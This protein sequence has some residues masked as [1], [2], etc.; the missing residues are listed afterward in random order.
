MKTIQLTSIHFQAQPKR[1]RS[2]VL[3]AIATL[4]GAAPAVHA[5]T[6]P[7]GGRFV[8]GGGTIVSNGNAMTINQNGPRGVLDWDSFSIGHG[9]SVAFN[10]GTGA[11]LNRVTGG[12]LSMIFGTLSATGSVY[13]V[14]PQGIVVGRSGTIATGGRFVAST[15]DANDS[16]FMKGGPLTLA[17]R[18]HAVVVNLG[19]IG[20]SGGDV[21]LIAHDQVLNLG[22]ISAPNGSAELAAGQTVLLQD[23]S[24]SRQVFVKAGSHGNV[25]N[26]GALDAAQI[27]L[28]AADG[29]VF[30][31]SGNHAAIRATGTAKRD[32]HVWLVADTGTVDMEATVSASN[33]NGTGGTVDTSAA[34]FAQD[35]LGATVRAAKWNLTTPR[36]TVTRS[37]GNTLTNS[38]NAG[39]SI[40]VATTQ[41]NIDVGTNL[42]WKGNASLTFDAYGS[43]A[44]DKGV[45][46]RNQGGGDLV[47]RADVTGIDNR[48]SIANNGTLD[49]SASTGIVTALYDMNGRYT[50]GTL[51][52][53]K[54]W[55]PAAGSGLVTQITGYRLVNSF[56]DLQNVSHD[57]AGNYALG[58]NL[59]GGSITPIGDPANAFSGQ[60]DGMGHSIA[61]LSFNAVYSP[62]DGSPLPSGLFGVI[63]TTGVVRNLSVSGSSESIVNPAY[64]M[65]PAG[66][67]AGLNQGH[68]ANVFASGSIFSFDEM[69]LGGLAG[70]NTGLIE[71]SAAS[72]N[73]TGR[74]SYMGG[75]VGQNDGTIAQSYSTGAVQGMQHP[76]VPAGLVGVNTGTIEQSFATGQ[77]TGDWQ[78]SPY[79][80]A[81]TSGNSGTVTADNYWNVE[82]T[83]VTNGGGAPS[84]HGLTTAQMGRASSF[85]GWDFGA[86]GAWLMPAGA[87][88]P[89]LRWQAASA[90]PPQ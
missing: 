48:G 82:T 90:L 3:A 45:A 56:G 74:Q 25:T 41:G 61:N 73:V 37:I 46:I 69:T 77:V 28:Q 67:V 63:G 53:N 79:I 80:G 27:S 36:F 1:F 62:V 10:N 40:D 29:N 50:P 38:L 14:N 32:G 21:V 2:L 66:L 85:A 6:L 89:V 19:Q 12:N 58:K 15:L 65:A 76:S 83:G 17:G 59:Q 20:S 78:V 8:A 57:L 87:T 49:W 72:V 33:A 5:G 7:S 43:V 68:I 64:T 26:V 39:T 60:F 35:P 22:S 75:L 71:R 44:V 86:N 55:T 16:A 88:H 13:L 11:T 31:L 18:S 9:N 4:Y 52:A 23:S 24:T 81:I 47:L 84:S 51:L 70:W 34:T 30:A 42:G 54:R